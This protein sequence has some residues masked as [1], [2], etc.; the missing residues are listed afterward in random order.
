MALSKIQTGLV[1]TN[2]VGATE[3]NLADNFAFTGDVS[4]AG[5]LLQVVQQTVQPTTGYSCNT[6]TYSNSGLAT[7]TITPTAASSKIIVDIQGFVMHVNV[8]ATNYGGSA[9]IYR[10]VAG[11]GY[12]SVSGSTYGLDG[13]YRND[14]TTD[15]WDDIV[16]KMKIVDTPSYTLGQ[17]I[18]YQI[19]GKRAARNSGAMYINHAGGIPGGNGSGIIMVRGILTEIAG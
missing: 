11:G 9:S 16:G 18:S 19:W 2:A 4:G 7:F 1:D 12:N 10:D 13:Y 8:Q 14:Q 6:T 15:H 17:T 3:L 5:N